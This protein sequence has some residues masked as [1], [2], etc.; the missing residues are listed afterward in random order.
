MP[1]SAYWPLSPPIISEVFYLK[2]A[3]EKRCINIE[4]TPLHIQ[5]KF[6][7]EH[8]VTS[9][10]STTNSTV[11]VDFGRLVGSGIRTLSNLRCVLLIWTAS[12]DQLTFLSTLDVQLNSLEPNRIQHNTT[13]ARPFRFPSDL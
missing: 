4:R 10:D 2:L 7:T 11:L 9:S 1:T 5:L 6:R 12:T 3:D 8:T 13:L